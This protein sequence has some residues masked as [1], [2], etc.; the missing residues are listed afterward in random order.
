MS[1]ELAVVIPTLN[2]VGNIVPLL[3][4]LDRVLDGIAWEAV[5]VDDDSTDG[6]TELLRRLAQERPNVRCLHRIGRS[7]LSSACIEGMLSTAAPHIAVMDADLQHDETLLP[8][9]LAKLKGEKLDIVVASRFAEG[10][11][12]GTFSSAR[13]RLSRVGIRLSRLVTGARLTDP[14]SGFFMLKREV[15]EETARNLSG[16]GFKILLD[17]FASAPRPLRFGEVPL[18]FRARHSGASKLDTLV[19][20]EFAI[21]LA[22]KL[23]GKLIPIRFVLFVLV[24][25]FGVGVHLSLLALA[26]RGIGLGFVAA[27]AT[28]TAAAMTVNF[29]LNNQ[30]TYRDRRL[31]G[32]RFLWGLASFY[33]ACAIGAVVN[34]QVAESLFTLGAPWPLAGLLG[35]T[36]GAVWNFG[37]SSTFTWSKPKPRPST[38]SADTPRFESLHTRGAGD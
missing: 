36:V 34:L 33:V 38:V 37:V 20:L 28:A 31:K 2:E 1:V 21:L 30:F 4:R 13:E 17:L 35:A 27:Q 7:G 24:G 32:R 11:S 15:L 29:Y 25:A 19:M 9:M 6:T 5:F 8:G 18:H 14:L 12:L 22:D 26:F 16:Q 3:Q 10:S 23:V